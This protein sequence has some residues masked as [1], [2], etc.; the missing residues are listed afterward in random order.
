MSSH[1]SDSHRR[2]FVFRA[3][4]EP[5][6]SKWIFDE[7]NAGRLRQGWGWS[8]L[9]LTL[10]GELVDQAEWMEAYKGIADANSELAAKAR[11]RILTRMLKF[12]PG[13][14]L[15]VPHVPVTNRFVLAVVAGEYRYEPGGA[16]DWDGSHCHVVPIAPE[17]VLEFG[18]D[19][20]ASIS[21]LV[22]D[23]SLAAKYRNA[24]TSEVTEA[25]VRD[26]V[27]KLL[28]K[29]G[30]AAPPPSLRQVAPPPAK[31]K[32][33]SKAPSFR[34][35]K[36]SNGTDGSVV[37]LKGE[38]L[39]VRWEQERLR[40]AGRSDLAANVRHV[41]VDDGDGAGYDVLS[42]DPATE[43]KLNIEV[44]TTKGGQT[45]SFWITANE[46]AFARAYP[47]GWRLYRV[48]DVD[49]DPRFHVLTELD[50]E[51]LVPTEYRYG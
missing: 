50:A 32:R 38:E 49:R 36:L 37:G 11:W 23:R 4:R 34:A 17:L 22:T 24:V 16:R 1:A 45:N 46:L 21:R 10:D 28:A 41:S 9:S 43:G 18:V 44:K 42:F 27:L 29:G 12:L 26:G 35:R 8:G 7:I 3:G 14:V 39:V 20:S 15:V 2:V 47:K 13:D 30:K 48:F 51:L 33:E 5:A 19:E 6:H 40:N 31:A 25:D